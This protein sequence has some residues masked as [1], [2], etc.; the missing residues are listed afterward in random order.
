MTP[1]QYEIHLSRI[2]D[3]HYKDNTVMRPYY[4]YNGNTYINKTVSLLRQNTWN[5]WTSIQKVFSSGTRIRIIVHKNHQRLKAVSLIILGERFSCFL[6]HD[7]LLLSQSVTS[8]S[9]HPAQTVTTVTGAAARLWPMTVPVLR[10]AQNPW[11]TILP[12]E[13]ANRL[14]SVMMISHEPEPPIN[15]Q[16]LATHLVS[17]M[18]KSH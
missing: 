3:S 16:E 5:S 6:H 17:V 15:L 7:K 9:A 8:Q 1:L 11:S 10:P 13:P 2:K 12:Q 4:L 14:V 18:M